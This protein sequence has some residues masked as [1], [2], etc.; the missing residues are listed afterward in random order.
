MTHNVYD[1]QTIELLRAALRSAFRVEI[2]RIEQQQAKAA[3]GIQPSQVP[4][5]H[6]NSSHGTGVPRAHHHGPAPSWGPGV[7]TDIAAWSR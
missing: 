4:L 5:L 6:C 3:D 1:D 7:V 2:E